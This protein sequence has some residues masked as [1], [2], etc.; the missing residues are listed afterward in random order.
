MKQKT[1]VKV[2]DAID[3]VLDKREVSGATYDFLQ[4]YGLKHTLTVT[5]AMMKSD[6]KRL[7]THRFA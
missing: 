3:E 6:I 4:R 5:R 2:L 1:L 7:L